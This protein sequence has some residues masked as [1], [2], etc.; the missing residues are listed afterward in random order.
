MVRRLCCRVDHFSCWSVSPAFEVF[1]CLFGTKRAVLFWTFS[2]LE[3]CLSLRG[4]QT[5]HAHTVMGRIKL[6]ALVYD[7][8]LSTTAVFRRLFD[9]AMLLTRPV[10]IKKKKKSV[11]SKRNFF[12][13]FLFSFFLPGVDA[14]HIYVRAWVLAV[15]STVLLVPKSFGGR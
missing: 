11:E 2:R 13:F 5:A 4:S 6:Q 7:I 3:I 15:V 8:L 9:V 12:F 1:R 14:S 10:Q